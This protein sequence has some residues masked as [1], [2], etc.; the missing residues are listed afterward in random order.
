MVSTSQAAPHAAPA[1]TIGRGL[2]RPQGERVE[3]DPADPVHALGLML[4]HHDGLEAWWSAG[5]FDGDRRSNDRWRAQ[6]VIAIDVD[7]HDELGQHA[8]APEPLNLAGVPCSL[9]H[10]TPRGARL[11]AWLSAPIVDPKAYPRAWAALAERVEGWLAGRSGWAVDRQ[12]KDLARF[13]WTPRAEVDGH[14]R[15]AEIVSGDVPVVDLA[16]LLV[17]PVIQLPV[18]PSPSAV[19]RARAWLQRAEPA[20]SGSGGH[21]IAF[22][23]I[24]RL[25]RGFRLS[26][27]DA[28]SALAEWNASCSPPWSEAELLHKIRDG[29]ERGDT[30]DGELL[31]RPPPKPE[32]SSGL[33]LIEDRGQNAPIDENVARM[34][35]RDPVWRGGP[36]FDRYSLLTLWPVPLPEP[37]ASHVRLDREIT[38]ADYSA[39]QA[40]AIREHRLRAARE[41]IERGARLA[42]ERHAIDTLVEW[43]AALPEWDG[44]PRL[45]TW[46]ARYLGCEDTTYHRT[47][48][49]AWLRACV[50]RARSPGL[51][52]DI[53]PILQGDQ[54]TA[55]NLA[56]STLFAGGP[57][58]APW[59]ALLGSWR[60][61]HPDTKRLA[62]SR[63]ILH[64]DEFSARDPKQ[65]D[66][67]KSWVSRD[68][69]QWTAK[70]SN[71]VT[72]M[73]R[74]A[75]LVCSVNASV[76]LSDPTGAR[77]WIV[78]K[79]GSI[80][81]E[82]I[83]RDRLQ[84]L[85]E[86]APAP[87]WREGLA[88]VAEAQR[89][90]AEAVTAEDGM[91]GMLQRLIMEGKWTTAGLAGWEIA[92]ALGVPP[93]RQDQAWAVRLGSAVSRLRGLSRKVTVLGGDRIRFYFP[94]DR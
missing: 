21:D 78:W 59:L 42:A 54:G 83:A 53:V 34:L 51:H 35:E 72:V 80:D 93:E 33:E 15:A 26:D 52:V 64:D 56:I 32:T 58:G 6:H 77:R 11:L 55:K 61:D 2:R 44:V 9:A 71:D 39:I 87:D 23:T 89:E 10:P 65:V 75:L 19:S 5:V 13:F 4:S 94:P 73:R 40:Y 27:A 31:D 16:S 20:V 49:R 45:D 41:T 38:S 81:V 92:S 37:V 14:A 70:Y 36:R 25:V 60:A 88:A 43:V 47:T 85:A 66:A 17:A 8:L 67:L 48:G 29:R 74:R 68:T 76:F 28:L 57:A 24:E 62:C 79:V 90:A 91:Q 50:A 82:A 7:Y 69:E 18:R 63:W 30:P 22:R 84:L 12:T 3:L 46:L 1:I 86:A